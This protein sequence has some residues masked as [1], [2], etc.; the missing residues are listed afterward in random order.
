VQGQVGRLEAEAIAADVDDARLHALQ[1]VGDLH[2]GAAV[3]LDELHLVLGA[4][5]D[6]LGHLRHEKVL[7]QVDVGVDGRVAGG[8]AQPDVLG[9]CP[10]RRDGHDKARAER[11]PPPRAQRAT[12]RDRH[13]SSD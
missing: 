11:K 3:A 8:N 6:A 5:G 1:R 12:D 4:L 10:I 7:H 2:H 13:V 9:A